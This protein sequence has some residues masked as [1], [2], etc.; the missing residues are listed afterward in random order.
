MVIVV[1]TLSMRENAPAWKIGGLNSCSTD[2]PSTWTGIVRVV[3][4]DPMA[5]HTDGDPDKDSPHDP[6]NPAD[7]IKN[8]GQHE[9]M[10]RPR[11]LQEPIAGIA[12]ELRLNDEPRRVPELEGA[13]QLPQSVKP[14]ASTM[15]KEIVTP[16]LS[17][18]P[19][20]DIVNPKYAER[21]R[22]PHQH[23]QPDQDT[24][25]GLGTVKRLVYESPVHPERMPE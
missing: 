3:G 4:H 1:P 19:I 8:G 14:D 12:G 23:T 17:L 9:L 18:G 22:H 24:F 10:Q 2:K 20:P 15:R 13:I 25:D 11:S 7:P 6:V 21:A 16:R 5:R